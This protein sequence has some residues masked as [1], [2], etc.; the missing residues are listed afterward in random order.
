[1]GRWRST[2]QTRNG[3]PSQLEGTHLTCAYRHRP[4]DSEP[5]K[6]MSLS[7]SSHPRD[8]ERIP[9]QLEAVMHKRFILLLGMFLAS[10]V[11]TAAQRPTPQIVPTQDRIAPIVTMVPT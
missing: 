5:S 9:A 11:L 1:M 10:H 3:V 7:S 4:G 2:K 8:P 6:V